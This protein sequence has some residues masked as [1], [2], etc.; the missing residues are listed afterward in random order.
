MTCPGP[1]SD[2]ARAVASLGKVE[3]WWWWWW[4]V[5]GEAH[6]TMPVMTKKPTPNPYSLLTDFIQNTR[7]RDADISQASWGSPGLLNS[8]ADCVYNRD[9]V[10]AVDR[11]AGRESDEFQP[12]KRTKLYGI[13]TA[14]AQCPSGKYASFEGET[15]PL[16][17]L[18]FKMLNFLYT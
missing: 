9:A 18:L 17:S 1:P 8:C 14:Y 7:R 4:L 12:Q 16:K 11:H 15:R 13:A 5:V 10:V 3:R 2:L 6:K